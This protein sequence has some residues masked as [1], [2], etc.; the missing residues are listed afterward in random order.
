MKRIIITG[1]G[2]YASGLKSS[3]DLLAGSNEQVIPIDFSAE[4]NE[5][6][7]KLKMSETIGSFP[8]DEFLFICDILG[9]TPFKNAATLA[10]SDNRIEVVAGC[11]LGSI[12]EAMFQKEAITL[13]D[14][15]DNIVHS[16]KQYTVKFE[17][18]KEPQTLDATS[19]DDGI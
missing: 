15:A 7:L 3:L 14:L 1:H 13:N 2:N 4:M 16:S 6:E 19:S 12:L 10:N 8:Q 11:N 17:K 5:V 18:I 9:G